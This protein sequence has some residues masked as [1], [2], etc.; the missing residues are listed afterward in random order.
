V[1]DQEASMRLGLDTFG[2][3]VQLQR[4]GS[5]D[6]REARQPARVLQPSVWPTIATSQGD[7]QSV[8]LQTH[9]ALK[10]RHVRY[11]SISGGARLIGT[12]QMK[13]ITGFGAHRFPCP[14]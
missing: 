10:V 3:D 9:P 7:G 1:L 14:C 11:R 2:D 6:E 8:A 4:V 5:R 12:K 13:R